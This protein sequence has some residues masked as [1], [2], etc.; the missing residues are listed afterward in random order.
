MSMKGIQHA[1]RKLSL[2][3]AARVAPHH[4]DSRQFKALEKASSTRKANSS[5]DNADTVAAVKNLAEAHVAETQLG[6]RYKKTLSEERVYDALV[7]SRERKARSA[8]PSAELLIDRQIAQEAAHFIFA[9]EL[10]L[11]AVKQAGADDNSTRGMEHKREYLAAVDDIRAVRQRLRS[12]SAA[13][14][15]ERRGASDT[16]QFQQRRKPK[17][18]AVDELANSLSVMEV[19]S[20]KRLQFGARRKGL[21]VEHVVPT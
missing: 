14:S 21:V 3:P 20:L 5:T 19:R 1:A 10:A 6:L 4:T 8:A 11:E 16:M 12:E 15:D 18:T 2:V 9:A 13:E 7:A 17:K